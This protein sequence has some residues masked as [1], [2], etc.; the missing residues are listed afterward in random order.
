MKKEFTIAHIDPMGQGVSKAEA[1]I[2]FIKKTLPNEIVTAEVFSKKKGVQF[3]KLTEIVSSS[4]QR[5][6]AACEHFNVCNGCDF[7]HTSYENELQFKK[8]ALKRHLFK[9]PDVNINLHP[10]KKRYEYRN[11][12]QLHYDK[13]KRLLG[14]LDGE[15]QITPVLNCMIV[16]PRV[17]FELKKLYF[18]QSWMKLLNK[19]PPTGHIEIY[20]HSK[21]GFTQVSVNQ[22]Y[23]DGGF[24]QVNEAMN[25]E[26]IEW[27]KQK[28][29]ELISPNDMV[30]DLF[31]GNGNLSANLSNKTLVVDYYNKKTPTNTRHQV[32]HSQNLYAPDALKNLIHLKLNDI[33]RPQWLIIDPPRSGLKNLKEYLN[34]FKPKGFIFIACDPTSFARDLK[35][36][37]DQ[38]EMK[39]LELFDLFPGTQH[40]ETIGIFTRR[41]INV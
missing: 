25:N 24:T 39:S 29:K 23:A 13:K 33:K 27:F 2:T 38:Y 31:G 36:V 3:A 20:F 28:T 16:E 12:I 35:D 1:E 30:Y 40:F 37:F 18:D 34:E 7:Q 9:F 41:D 19:E 32:F 21:E 22:P 5:I 6:K 10:A 17:A 4:P 14:L 15:Q 26:M 8:A 11:R